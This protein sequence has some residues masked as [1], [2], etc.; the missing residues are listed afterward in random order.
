MGMYHLP[1][2]DRLPGSK[3]GCSGFD[4]WECIIFPGSIGCHLSRRHIDIGESGDVKVVAVKPGCSFSI[5]Y[6]F[7]LSPDP[8][9]GHYFS[10]KNQLLV[11]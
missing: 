6:T 10:K 1:G 8:T 11:E 5:E 7:E 4:V 9:L 2:S 3:G